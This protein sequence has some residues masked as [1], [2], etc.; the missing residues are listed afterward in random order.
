MTKYNMTEVKVDLIG[1]AG[2][3]GSF[4]QA[5]RNYA[6]M[7]G[8][9]VDLS[10]PLWGNGHESNIMSEELTMNI[11][12]YGVKPPR[13]PDVAIRFEIPSFY[14]QAQVKQI[15]YLPWGTTK[16]PSQKL[17]LPNSNLTPDD[18][19]WPGKCNIMDA[20]ISPSQFTSDV[21]TRSGI[22]K[23]VTVIGG[24]V[25]TSVFY[26][27]DLIGKGFV[28]LTHKPDGTFIEKK[29]RRFIVGMV[30]DWNLR[31]NID[32]FLRAAMVALP[33]NKAV[34]AIKTSTSHPNGGRDAIIKRIT[35]LKIAMKLKDLPPVILIDDPLNEIEM[36]DFYNTLDVYVST[37]RGEGVNM[38][39]LE[40][41]ACECTVVASGC[42]CNVEY[43]K[44][45]AGIIIPVVH[46]IVSYEE[47]GMYS[48]PI[49]Y[50]GD[51][52][53]S[54]L[55]ELE[56]VTAINALFNFRVS[57]TTEKLEEQRKMARKIVEENYSFNAVRQKVLKQI[58][59]VLGD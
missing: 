36:A 18:F 12:K 20:M 51:M 33:P 1:N 38:A 59:K 52:V 57:G 44:S 21:L 10:I 4:S 50:Q 5:L 34:L 23:P 42:G 35:N 40:A 43:L 56:L 26:K 6:K 58:R 32:G 30:A 14:K 9:D 55:S 16:L 41:M 28:G 15:G 25:D 8:E 54:K 49:W 24:P 3:R 46:D 2:L 27:R 13:V 53:W 7:I 17:S 45:G 47:D 22:T 39:L 48:S 31:K 19:F 37:T 11:G 29:D